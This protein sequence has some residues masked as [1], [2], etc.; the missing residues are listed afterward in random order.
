MTDAAFVLAAYGIVLGSLV[1]YAISLA[2]RSA[3]AEDVEQAIKHR[4]NKR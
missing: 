3:A 2:R 4:L 1:A